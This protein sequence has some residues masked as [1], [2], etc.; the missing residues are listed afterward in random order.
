LEGVLDLLVK[1]NCI[2]KVFLGFFGRAMKTSWNALDWPQTELD[3]LNWKSHTKLV[4]KD[5][6]KDSTEITQTSSNLINV[7]SLI[8]N[9]IIQQG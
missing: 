4:N 1:R 5:T 6:Q 9:L 3:A 8:S 7:L 2:Y